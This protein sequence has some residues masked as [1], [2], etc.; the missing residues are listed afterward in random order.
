MMGEMPLHQ[1]PMPPTPEQ[2]EMLSKPSWEQV[3]GLIKDNSHRKYKIDIETD[4][5]IAGSMESDM[6]GLSQV[7]QA[8]FGS[9]QAMAG[10]VSSGMM[11]IDA[12]KEILLTITRRSRMGLA[13]ED[14]IDKMAAP[15]PQQNPAIE[16]AQIKQQSDQAKAQADLRAESQKMQLQ[17]Q[18][19]ERNKQV[20]L[21]LKQQELAMKA[22]QDAINQQNAMQVEA[23]KQEMQAQQI[24]HQNE[25]EAQRDTL[26]SQQEAQLQQLKLSQEERANELDAK[27]Q[28][29]IAQMNNAAKIQVAEIKQGSIIEFDQAQAARD[30]SDDSYID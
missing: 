16:L 7:I 20:D 3:I 12:V 22:H 18:M 23:H 19:D 29:M 27:L 5:T 1:P 17:A 10:M 2:M 4:S 14:A 21:Q 25:L 28:L 8:V 9:Y 11:P 26:R 13:V 15:Q 24:Q 6:A 30:A